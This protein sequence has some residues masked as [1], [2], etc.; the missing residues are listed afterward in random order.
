MYVWMGYL[1]FTLYLCFWQFMAPFFTFLT[2]LTFLYTPSIFVSGVRYSKPA[3]HY[4][5]LWEVYQALKEDVGD[6]IF[7]SNSAHADLPFPSSSSL[8]SSQVITQNSSRYSVPLFLFRVVITK[9][10]IPAKGE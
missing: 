10:A 6:L 5:S 2:F 3:Y 7:H 4:H 1:I 9:S 8:P